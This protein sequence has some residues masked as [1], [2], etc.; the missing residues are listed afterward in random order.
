MKLDNTNQTLLNPQLFIK[1][2][3]GQGTIELIDK[4]LQQKLK[5]VTARD[6]E[7]TEAMDIIKASRPRALAKGL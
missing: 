2:E 1:R 6:K 5:E 4:Q 7:V 3:T